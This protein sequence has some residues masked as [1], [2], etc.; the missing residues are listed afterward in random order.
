MLNNYLT[1]RTKTRFTNAIK[2]QLAT[3]CQEG[4]ARLSWTN[5]GGYE[6][7]LNSKS[8]SGSRGSSVGESSHSSAGSGL[9]LRSPGARHPFRKSSSAPDVWE[10]SPD[11]KPDDKKCSPPT[12]DSALIA[13]YAH[14]YVTRSTSISRLN[15]ADISP[16][17]SS[18]STGSDNTTPYA[19]TGTSTSTPPASPRHDSPRPPTEEEFQ[20]FQQLL[21]L[22]LKPLLPDTAH[23]DAPT[24]TYLSQLVQNPKDLLK[25]LRVN[26][27]Q[28]SLDVGYAHYLYLIRAER[29][30]DAASFLSGQLQP[31]IDKDIHLSP[32]CVPLLPLEN[33]EYLNLPIAKQNALPV[34]DFSKL[35]QRLTPRVSTDSA[36][37]TPIASSSPSKPHRP[38]SSSFYHPGTSRAQQS[39]SLS[40]PPPRLSVPPPSSSHA[41]GESAVLAVSPPLSSSIGPALS[42]VSNPLYFHKPKEKQSEQPD[43]SLHPLLDDYQPA[44]PLTKAIPRRP[45]STS[46]LNIFMAS[47]GQE[48]EA[49]TPKD[50]L[51]QGPE[52]E[53]PQDALMTGFT[54]TY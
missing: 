9:F 45:R 26:L 20:S 33:A 51:I 14:E 8:G 6:M 23:F 3:M 18:S 43:L 7:F 46:G 30:D 25:D 38:R 50:T 5:T 41:N 37:Y 21:T 32:L 40:V 53:T 11:M 16:S 47:G 19:E 29:L 4:S 13:P 27:Q 34:E 28:W 48:S 22:I 52:T 42:V 24:R 54:P 10:G 2:D 17:Q 1:T 31:L 36:P 49:E 15:L 39:R 35:A 44:P 12:D